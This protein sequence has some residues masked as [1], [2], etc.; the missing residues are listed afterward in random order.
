[1]DRSRSTRRSVSRA[2]L[3]TPS[4]LRTTRGDRPSRPEAG[5]RDREGGRIGEI[6]DLGLPKLNGPNDPND[7]NVSMSPTLSMAA[8]QAGAILGTAAYMS[9][10]QA[11]GKQVDK[12]ADLWAFGV[13]LYEMVTASRFFQGEDL[14]ETLASVVKGEP[15]LSPAP[16]RVRRLLAKCLANDPRNRLRDIG[17]AWELLSDAFSPV[18]LRMASGSRSIGPAINRSR[19]CRSQVARRLR[20]R[21]SVPILKAS[22][23]IRTTRSCTLSKLPASGESLPGVANRYWSWLPATPAPSRI[24]SFCRVPM[25]YWRLLS[26]PAH[27]AS[28]STRR[29]GSRRSRARYLETGHIVYAQNDVLYAVPVDLERLQPLGAAVPLVEN[30]Q[31]DPS[32]Y[33][34]SESGTLVY[35][36]GSGITLASRSVLGWIDLN[37]VQTSTAVTRRQPCS[38][39]YRR[40]I[41]G[42]PNLGLRSRRQVADPATRRERQQLATDLDS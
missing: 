27:R 40:R 30:V 9:P 16:S 35:V 32:Q 36:R 42:K 41:R 15:D 8:T 13:L 39:L 34:V 29:P 17:D 3:P 31:P 6:L 5:Q 25:Y 10:E 19:R 21:P 7:P 2:R 1:M 28:S 4:K 11:R 33:A 37:A 18:F 24:L 38:R 22:R 20:W 26:S 12:R 23:G 14:A